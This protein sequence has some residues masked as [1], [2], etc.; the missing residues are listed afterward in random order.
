MKTKF[1]LLKL[2]DFKSRKVIHYSL[3]ICILL[4]QLLIAG[5][6]IMSL[7]QEKTNPHRKPTQRNQLTRNSNCRF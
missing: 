3:I 2:L 1:S 7:Y 5:F 4:I 6:F